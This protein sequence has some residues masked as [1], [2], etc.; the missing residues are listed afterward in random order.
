MTSGQ[1]QLGRWHLL[2][3]A[4]ERRLSLREAND[5][6]KISYRH[7]KRI[8]GVS[9]PGW[10]QE[11]YPWQYGKVPGQCRRWDLRQKILALS[12]TEY[13]RFND[14]HFTA[15]LSTVEGIR[16]RRETVRK[17]RGGLALCPRDEDVLPGIGSAGL[18]SLSRR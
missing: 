5:R 7:A 6:M 17:I 4:L 18:E 3:M 15:K 10:P 8:K 9:C 2:G 16:I 13:A 1:K 12:R 14:T 11:A